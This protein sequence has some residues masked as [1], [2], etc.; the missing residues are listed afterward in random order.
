[1]SAHAEE[2]RHHSQVPHPFAMQR[3]GAGRQRGLHQFQEGEHDALAGQQL[4]QLGYELL[5][6]PRPLRVARAVGEEDEGSLDF[7]L[8]FSF[9]HV[10]IIFDAAASR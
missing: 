10:W 7:S 3:R 8:D 1:M 9:G 6:R 5:E 4:T 2:H